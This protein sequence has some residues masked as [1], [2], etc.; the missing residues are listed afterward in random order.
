MGI[1]I[2]I[3]RIR[4]KMEEQMSVSKWAYIPAKCDGDFCPGDCDVCSKAKDNVAL[5]EGEDGDEDV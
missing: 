4:K 3:E 5:M 2:P 1:I